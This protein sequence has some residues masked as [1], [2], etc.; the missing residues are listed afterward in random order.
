MRQAGDREWLIL[1]VS[2]ANEGVSG[3]AALT[4]PTGLT[5]SLI[6]TGLVYILVYT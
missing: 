3:Y 4:R 6:F 2:G 1:K 5:P